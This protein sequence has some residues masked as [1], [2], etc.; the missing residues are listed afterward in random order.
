LQTYV[1][2]AQ[3]RWQIELYQRQET[4]DWLL[5]VIKGSAARLGLS[6][7]GCEL[8]LIDVYARVLQPQQ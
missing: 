3:D 5:S 6:A 2:V 7:I 8:A 4:D 1:L